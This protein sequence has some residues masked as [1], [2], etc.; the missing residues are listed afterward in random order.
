MVTASHN[1]EHDNGEQADA[2]AH[3]AALH[4]L[5]PLQV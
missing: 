3:V 1:P 4:P 2:P 5:R